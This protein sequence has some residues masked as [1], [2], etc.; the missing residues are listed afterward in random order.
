M[1]DRVERTL[2]TLHDQLTNRPIFVAS[3]CRIAQLSS[4]NCRP[5][6]SD[7]VSVSEERHTPEFQLHANPGV[8]QM[9][10]N[11]GLNSWS[12]LDGLM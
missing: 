2:F 6:G 11:P 12:I 4:R 5:P 8:V 3:N 1:L 9:C 10:T 7:A